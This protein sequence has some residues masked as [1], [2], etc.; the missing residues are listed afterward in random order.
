MPCCGTA[1]ALLVDV[2]PTVPVVIKP[3]P[4]PLL[5]MPLKLLRLLW[6]SGDAPLGESPA[7]ESSDSAPDSDG[8]LSS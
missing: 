7:D 5:R 4:L 1:P 3:L 2:S 6:V 8:E